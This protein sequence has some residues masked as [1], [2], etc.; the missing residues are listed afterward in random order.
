MNVWSIFFPVFFSLF[1]SKFDI[2][3]VK[4]VSQPR[5]FYRV[6]YYRVAEKIILFLE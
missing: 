6:I 1:V 4:A 5:C 2:A 3:T